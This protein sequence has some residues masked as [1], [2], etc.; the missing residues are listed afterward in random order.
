[1]K[2]RVYRMN[3][4]DYVLNVIGIICT[5]LSIIGAYKSLAYYKKNKYLTMYANASLA[6]IESQKIQAILVEMVKL[7]TSRKIRGV[8]I[9]AQSADNASQIRECISRIRD[10]LTAEDSKEISGM[11]KSQ[12]FHV[13]KYIDS[14]ISGA[15]LI[16]GKVMIDD[17]FY[18]CQQVFTD[19]QLLLKKKMEAMEE[20]NK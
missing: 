9:E 13:E 1:M 20:K 19:M 10:S 5:V 12:K 3:W 16:D 7:S 15:A 14:F 2:T 18:T 11:L 17:N 6:Y 8:N 4:W